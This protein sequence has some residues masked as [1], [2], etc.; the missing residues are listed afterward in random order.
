[1]TSWPALFRFKE[2]A[3]IEKVY[4]DC[5]TH[6]IKN[7]RFPPV[8]APVPEYIL[9]HEQLLPERYEFMFERMSKHSRLIAVAFV[10]SAY[11]MLMYSDHVEGC[12]LEGEDVVAVAGYY[13][14][15][16]M[17]DKPYLPVG[18]EKTYCPAVGSLITPGRIFYDPATDMIYYK[19]AWQ[20]FIGGTPSEFKSKKLYKELILTK[21]KDG[22]VF[23]D[24]GANIY[25]K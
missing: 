17:Q 15:S 6:A 8:Y 9:R 2:Y 19:G 12:D 13:D 1:M 23:T 7:L 4:Y 10:N 21:N 20:K 3:P 16:S 25:L 24:T 18:F 11:Y 5:E 22:V 14:Y